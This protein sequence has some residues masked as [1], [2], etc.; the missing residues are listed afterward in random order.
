MKKLLSVLLLLVLV[1]SN[2]S[3]SIKLTRNGFSEIVPLAGNLKFEFNQDMVP[4]EKVNVWDTAHYIVFDPP[5]QGKFKWKNK[6][7]LVFSP[8]HYLRPSTQ[9]KARFNEMADGLTVDDDIPVEFHTPFF[10]IKNFEAYLA[11]EILKSDQTVIRYDFEFNYRIRPADLKE[12]LSITLNGKK[13][14]YELLSHEVSDKVSVI[15]ENYEIDDDKAETNVKIAKGLKILNLALSNADLTE[16]TEII[17]PDDFQIKKIEADHDGFNGTV[18][19]TANQDV[20]EAN[21]RNYIDISPSVSYTVSVEG[22]KIYVK[23]EKFDIGKKYTINVKEG[24]SGTLG[25]KLKYEYTEEVSFGKLDPEIKIMNRKAEYLSGKGLKNLEVR[26]VS[27]PKVRVI[28]KKVYKNNLLSYLSSRSYYDNYYYDD[29]Y[30]YDGPKEVGDLGDLVYEKE[31]ATTSLEVSNSGRLLNLDFED[32]IGNHDGVYVIEV[33]SVDDYWLKARKIVSI[34]DIGLIAKKGIDNLYIF[35]N[36]IES[37]KPLSG[38]KLEITGKNNQVLG[39]VETN[40]NGFAVYSLKNMPADGF[41]PSL[42]TAKMG[43]DFNFLPFNRTQIGTSRFEISG[44]TENLSGY[45]AFI[46][47]DRDIYRPGETMHISVI[48]RNEEWKAPGEIPV[49]MKLYAPNG[50]VFKTIKKTLNQYGSFE[51]DVVIPASAPTGSYNVEV[52]TSTNVYLNSKSIKV[53]EFVPDRI[54]VEVQSDKKELFIGQTMNL[55]VQANNLFGPPATNRN[56]EIQESVKRSYFYT[57]KYR[58]YYFGLTGGKTYFDSNVRSGK[59]NTEGQANE[60]YTYPMSYADMGVLRA[61]YYVTVFDETGRPVNRRTSAT[62][63]TQDKFYGIDLEDYYN[64][65]DKAMRIPLI[66]VDKDGK[67]LSGVKANVKIIKHEYRT[68][69]AKSGSYYRYKSEHEEV[70]KYNKT[71]DLNGDKTILTYIPKTSGRYDIR[72]SKPGTKTYVQKSF[73]SYGWGA[74]TTSSFQVNNEG[75]IDIELDKDKYQVGDKA[76]VILNTPFSGKVLVTVERKNVT[77]HFYLKTDKRAVSFDLDIKDD[78]VP[79]VYVSATLIKPHGQ[80]D[81]PLTVAHGY[82]PVM[83]ENP[84]NKIPITITAVEKSHSKTKQKIKIKS[85]PNTAMTIAVVDE[86]ILQ[87]T[88]FQTPNPYTFFY[89]KRALAVNSYNIYPYLF[90]EIAMKTGKEGG[91]AGE[92]AKRVNP[93]TNKRFKLVSFWSGIKTT[94]KNGN[95]EYEIDIPQFS[96]DLR[97]MAVAYNGK[98][99]GAGKANMKVADPVVISAAL[100]RFLSPKDTIEMSVNLSNTTSNPMDCDLSIDVKGPVKMLGKDAEKIS[101]AANS[102]KQLYYKLAAAPELGEANINVLVNANGKKYS[103]ETDISIRPAS[104]LQKIDGSGVIVAG[105]QQAI[106]MDMQRFMKQSIDNK[107]LVSNSPLVQFSKDLDYLVRYPYGCVEQTVSAAFPQLYYADLAKQLSG[108]A[109]FDADYNIKA[110][111]RKLQLMQ[112]YN[113]ALSYWPGG[114]YESWWGSVYGAHFLIE[115][116]R[117]GYEVDQSVIDKLMEYLKNQLKR[118][119]RITYWYNGNKN[120]KIAPKEV[121]YSL[122]VMALAGK[123][124]MSY[125]NYY[126]SRR[127]E[128]SLDAKYLLATAYALTGD[129]NK[130]QQIVPPEFSGEESRSVFGG[131][132]HSPIRDEAISLNAIL[133]VDP[134]S[135]Q[136]GIMAKHLSEK[137]K[138]RRYLS[139]QERVFAFLAMGKI[140]KQAAQS[141]ISGEIL[142]NN[143]KVASYNNN[144]VSLKTDQ[145]KGGDISIKTNGKGR[146]YYFWEAEGISEDGSY[147][148]E[149]KYLKVRKT[150]YD[151]FGK[152]I[153]NRQFKQNDLVVIKLSIQGS[154]STSIENVVISDILPAGFEIENPR[155]SSVPGMGWTKNK[156]YPKYTDIR[157]DRINYFVTV[158]NSLKNY[159]YVVRAVT[160]GTFQM[161]PVGADAMYN[162]EYHSYSGGGV[163][164]IIRN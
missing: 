134:G 12:K 115:A 119:K 77:D 98:A 78:F 91:G 87:V 110:A 99:F 113:G 33:R 143:Q 48:M 38:V 160:P 73:Y 61:D 150:F 139:T 47:G 69:L 36:S 75:N 49:K 60:T 45:D 79:N 14:K 83:V 32:K 37:A 66:A 58:S 74:T 161:G 127:D 57:K 27:V 67:A 153:T 30:Y 41:A 4:D 10:E 105:S 39:N 163:I 123:P 162:G 16:K 1:L 21:I 53:E 137:M 158:T 54:K 55:K 124:K 3:E 157:D 7:E 43:A 100:P 8:Y 28:I 22:R 5:L 125:M 146:L 90:P 133:E 95:L 154:Y 104:P 18:T 42:I 117:A 52:Y 76:K 141:K 147:L 29:Y 103:N 62:I 129:K 111:I 164:K 24:L 40:K 97:I 128:L 71:I 92:L 88:G 96:G 59:T 17:D 81:I 11:K 13:V 118:K 84:A 64:K 94:D 25:G 136:V 156:G 101:I 51:T 9:Y 56:Y 20:V 120:K 144:T 19:I 80:S 109:K 34:S 121:A 35:A 122:Y 85:K 142:S 131:S 86:G 148:E 46:Y 152:Q 15:V 126:K 135:Q 108:S 155:I 102:E 89:R 63:Y 116:K 31:I 145:L 44:K 82:M 2:C 140:A 6:R 65:T 159:Y 132:F 23:S 93:M 68:V 149:D 130:Y 72:I 151:R 107:L 138:S 26:I 70:V 50:K 106:K 114:G 112:L